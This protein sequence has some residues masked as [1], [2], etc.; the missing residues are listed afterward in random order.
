MKK[1]FLFILA[2]GAVV[3]LSTSCA[4][5]CVCT[6]TEDGKKKS[7]SYSKPEQGFFDKKIC[8]NQSRDEWQAP[9]ATVKNPTA[10]TPHVTHKVTCKLQ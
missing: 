8:E 3:A 2:L 7:Q 6:H 5:N 1:R 4:K 9:S 10:N